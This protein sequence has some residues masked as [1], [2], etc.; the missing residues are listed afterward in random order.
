MFF[1][2]II[3][4][5]SGIE[6]RAKSIIRNQNVCVAIAKMWDTKGC[7]LSWT[8]FC[9]CFEKDVLKKVGFFLIGKRCVFLSDILEV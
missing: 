9:G 4:N 2:E 6:E 3:Y 1:F 5:I 8:S 7:T